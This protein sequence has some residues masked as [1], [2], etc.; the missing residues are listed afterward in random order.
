MVAWSGKYGGKKRK[1]ILVW[2][3]CEWLHKREPI[4]FFHRSTMPM[5]TS[6]KKDC[7]DPEIC[8]HGNMTSHFSS[9]LTNLNKPSQS[10]EPIR[11]Q[12]KIQ[13][14]DFRSGKKRAYTSWLLSYFWL[15][16]KRHMTASETTESGKAVRLTFSRTTGNCWQTRFALPA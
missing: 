15:V 11:I 13:V 14:A 2:L 12:K 5:A 9:L 6:V 7:W 8:Y 4:L 10:S 3:S 1:N 16:E